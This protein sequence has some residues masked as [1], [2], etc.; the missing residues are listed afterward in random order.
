[1]PSTAKLDKT[2]VINPPATFEDIK[3]GIRD[4]IG[5]GIALIGTAITFGILARSIGLSSGETAV[6]SAAVFAGASQIAAL[7][8]L[9][10]GGGLLEILVSTLLINSRF[11]ASS[12][13]L[14]RYLRHTRRIWLPFL[15]FGIVD[16]LLALLVLRA[17]RYGKIETY[18]LS[19]QSMQILWWVSGSVA[20]YLLPDILTPDLREVI[21]FSFPA[22]LIG[23]I[24]LLVPVARSIWKTATGY[25]VALTAGIL[26][27]AFYFIVPAGSLLLAATVGA[28]IGAFIQWKQR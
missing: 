28:T 15:A 26:A 18:M 23:L 6:F 22:L 9:A 4:S 21:S 13:I 7:N 1:M 14:S 19:L 17:E 27:L 5:T 12:V 2:D 25:V 24:V 10:L 3:A 11:M 20:G 8:I 16:T